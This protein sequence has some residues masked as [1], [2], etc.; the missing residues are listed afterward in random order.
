MSQFGGILNEMLKP[1]LGKK[2]GFEILAKGNT[3]M[4]AKMS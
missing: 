3:E 4:R 2:N 1:N